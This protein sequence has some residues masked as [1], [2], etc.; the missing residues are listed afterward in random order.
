[1]KFDVIIGNPPY[2]L[3]IGNE[4]GN[5][6]KATSLYHLF[7]EKSIELK[8]KYVTMII[9]SRWMTRSVSGIPISWIDKM[10]NDKRIKE[11]HD[12]KDS[13]SLFSGVNVGGGVNYFLWD[14]NHNGDCSFHEHFEGEVKNHVGPLNSF[15]SNVVVR[16]VDSRSIISKVIKKEGEYVENP[17]NNFY[18]M[19]SPKDFFC[20]DGKFTS[21]WKDYSKEKSNDDDIKYYISGSFNDEDI[22][23]VNDSHVE[24]NRESI[25]LHKVY[26]AAA[27]SFHDGSSFLGVPRYGEPNSI[28]SQTYLVIGYD[29]NNHNLTKKQCLNIMSY[30]RTR[31]FRFMVSIK[32]NTQNG[33]RGVYQFVPLQDWN[34]TWTDEEL[35]KKYKLTQE[36]I[37]YIEE[38]VAPMPASDD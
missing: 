25:G 34:K 26:I 19:V 22:G 17:N 8:P 10:M 35:Y 7:V 6:F 30:I 36:E 14:R 11:I 24:R 20:S 38:T 1:M 28:C 5:S 18:S 37:D 31:F 12:F 29:K 27:G 9:P 3:N 23:W 4:G 21:T 15:N 2:Q 32:K 33:A 13:S 16:S